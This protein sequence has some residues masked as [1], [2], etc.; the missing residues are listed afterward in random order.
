MKAKLIPVL[1][2]KS[3][4]MAKDGSYT[5]RVDSSLTKSVIKVLIEDTFGVNVK[6]VR[7]IKEHGGVKRTW[8]GR[9]RETMPSKKA[10]VSLKG[11]DKID[12][13]EEATK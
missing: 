13:F 7:T 11:K 12:L 1:T 3:I 9:K 5:F 8:R 4:R 2:E 6:N 10:I